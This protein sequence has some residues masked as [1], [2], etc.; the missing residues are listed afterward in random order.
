[1]WGRQTEPPEELLPL[2]EPEDRPPP[3]PVIEMKAMS[4]NIPKPLRKLMKS[5][6]KTMRI[7]S[8]FSTLKLIMSMYLEKLTCARAPARPLPS[9]P[10][11]LLWALCNRVT[12]KATSS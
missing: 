2:P 12:S 8:L 6:P 5:T 4:D 3:P 1:M 10:L 11:S 7:P 9:I